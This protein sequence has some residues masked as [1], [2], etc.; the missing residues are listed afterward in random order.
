MSIRR[1]Y[2]KPTIITFSFGNSNNSKWYG[3]DNVVQALYGASE[4]E[5][6]E[7]NDQFKK[8]QGDALES[9]RTNYNDSL[10]LLLNV[11]LKLYDTTNEFTCNHVISIF[12][13]V[14]KYLKSPINRICFTRALK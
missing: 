11:F 1:K 9:N 12:C 8:D 13:S 2:L 6:N 3:I 5:K 14:A 10:T 4:I 7:M